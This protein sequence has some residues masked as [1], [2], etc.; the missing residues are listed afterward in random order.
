MGLGRARAARPIRNRLRCNASFTF[1]PYACRLIS[2]ALSIGLDR[3]GEGVATLK[4]RIAIFIDGANLYSAA[5]ALG[6]DID[7]KRLLS[8]FQN[9]GTLLRAFYY[10]TKF[11][12]SESSVRPLVDWLDYNGYSVVT[13]TAQ[14]VTD[15]GGRRTLRGNVAVELAVNAMELARYLEQVFLFSGDGCLRALVEA[16]Q[17]RGVHVTVVSTLSSQPPMIADE[18]RRQAD[19]FLELLDLQPKIGRHPRERLMRAEPTFAPSVFQG[20]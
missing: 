11:P 6:F 4:N 3:Q 5:K 10:T 14:E 20:K 17:S 9:R 2:D 15:I 19:S 18:L 12:N 1:E 8:E 7:F 16:L 13:K